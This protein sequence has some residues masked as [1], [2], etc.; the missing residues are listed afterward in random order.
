MVNFRKSKEVGLINSEVSNMFHLKSNLIVYQS[1]GFIY[2]ASKHK[3]D[4][5]SIR[6]FYYAVDSI[7]KII[8]NPYFI[9]YDCVKN[10]LR[11]YKK[12]REYV[13]LVINLTET[14]AY[15][16]TIYPVNKKTI[17]KLKNQ[18]TKRTICVKI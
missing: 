8:S 18:N 3:N 14:Y 2:H 11:Y 7:P 16:S 12:I 13:C 17:D 9:Y 6:D 10:S 4:F 15:V 5:I 1:N